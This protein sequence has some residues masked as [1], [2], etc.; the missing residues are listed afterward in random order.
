MRFLVG[1]MFGEVEI[2]FNQ[3]RYSSAFTEDVTDLLFINKKNFEALMSTFPK[4]KAEL[5]AVA[6]EKI[7]RH[8]LALKT[9]KSKRI[10]NE[11]AG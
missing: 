11:L 6:K 5:K 2:L 7:K 4:I 3:L 1:T 9:T 10:L 8:S